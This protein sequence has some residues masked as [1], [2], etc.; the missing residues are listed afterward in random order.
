MFL[1]ICK[2]FP[3]PEQYDKNHVVKHMTNDTVNDTKK[4]KKTKKNETSF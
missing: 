3:I 4:G 1:I 2:K